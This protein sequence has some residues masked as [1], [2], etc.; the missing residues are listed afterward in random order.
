MSNFVSKLANNIKESEGYKNASASLFGLYVQALTGDRN[1]L[2]RSEVKKL[3]S[4]AQIFYQAESKALINEGAVLLSMLLDLCA[5]EHP[6]IVPIAHSMF[7]NSGNFPNIRLLTKRYPE[8]NYRYDFYSEAQI[9]F[10]ESLNSVEELNFPLTDYQ[11]SLWD[12]LTSDQD[13]ITSAPTSAGKTHIILSYLLKKVVK[14]DGSFAAIVVPTRALISEVAS[15]I[16]ELA[17]GYDCE[18]QIEICTVPKEGGFGEKTFFVMTQE[19][20]HEILLHGDVY[21]DY[22]F[23][24]EAHNISDK[25]RGVFLHL[26]I[27]KMLEDSYPQVIISMPSPNYQDSFST[28]F[29]G[30]DFK[31]EITQT[32]PVAKVIM[33]V[34]PKGRNLVL[35]RHNSTNVKSIPKEFSKKNLADIV[36]RLGKGQSNIIYR[37]K[38]DH[39][40][41]VAN[42][43]ADRITDFEVTPLLE[44][45]ADYIGEF[46]HEEFSLANNL[47]KGV[48]FHYG[49]L[50]GSVRVM[51][52]N[53]VKNDDIKYIAC[54]ST[55]AEG[56][57]LP[58]K[59]LF[60]KN[61]ANLVMHNPSERVDDVKINNI[62]GRAGRMLE[63]FSGNIFLV[64]PDTWL[65]KDYFDDEPEEGKKIPT[66][67]KSL[68]EEFGSVINA[69]EGRI[70]HSDKDQF[71]FYTIANKL[72]KEFSTN[73]LEQTLNAEELTLNSGDKDFLRSKVEAAHNDLK[74]ASFTLEANPTVGYIQQNKLFDFLGQQESF[75]EWVLPHPKSPDLYEALIRICDKLNEFGVYIPTENYTLKH[76]CVIT[77]KWVQ[78]DSLKEMISEQ[79]EWDVSCAEENFKSPGSV[80][81]SVRNVIKVIN[82]DI[83]FRLSNS[84]KCYQVLLNSVLAARG[85]ELSN[86]KLHSFIEIGASDDRMINM[87]NMGLSREAAKEIDEKVSAAEAIETSRDLVNLLNA[88]RLEKIHAITKKELD[89]LFS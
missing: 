41:D 84:L 68:N 62:T 82:N 56:V 5:D 53:L 80:N 9:E 71:R 28:I 44:E 46:I 78:G 31:K 45:A 36:C 89:E 38:T 14:S 87:I 47:R 57:N 85:V 65:F 86:V 13:V 17:K 22:L 76:I 12:D 23:I 54:T 15:K 67:F 39:C 19:R 27:E 4:S 40:E 16:Y 51:V 50:P 74:V 88:N 26:T 21:F 32:S 72:I 83:R 37:N 64:E 73:K 58:A 77:R 11:R 70:S 18:D 6:D 25:S 55:L 34:V 8:L 61:P 49:P 24:D 10:R 20:L 30:I 48:A 52:E 29:K 35:S 66:Y 81:T 7:A 33:S 3:V 63:H 79:R 43:I 59:N 42:A 69:L 1:S 75:R 2:E 60:L